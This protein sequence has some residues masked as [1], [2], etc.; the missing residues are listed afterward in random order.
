MMLLCKCVGFKVMEFFL[1]HPSVDITDDDNHG[2]STWIAFPFACTP[3]K[4][5]SLIK[6]GFWKQK[7]LCNRRGKSAT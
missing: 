4:K 1:T 2:C 5:M 6:L 7:L 3:Y